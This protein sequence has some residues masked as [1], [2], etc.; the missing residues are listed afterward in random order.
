MPFFPSKFYFNV[1]SITG[2]KND[3]IITCKICSFRGCTIHVVKKHSIR[4]HDVVFESDETQIKPKKVKKEPIED[5]NDEAASNVEKAQY[6]KPENTFSCDKCDFATNKKDNVDRHLKSQ[7]YLN[8]TM[9]NCKQCTF[10]SCNI[11]GLSSHKRNEHNE[12]EKDQQPIQ[13]NPVNHQPIQDN[14]GSD[15]DDPNAELVQDEVELR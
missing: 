8:D 12:D 4:E 13:D 5:T 1:F 3:Q 14:P 10:K 6:E 2:Y 15:G 7:G 9:F 11:N